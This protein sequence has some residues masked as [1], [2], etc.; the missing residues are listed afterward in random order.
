MRQ[1]ISD[2]W[3]CPTHDA[4]REF[5]TESYSALARKAVF[6]LQRIKASGV[7]GDDYHHKTLW[8]EYCHEVKEGPYDLLEDAWEKT[9]GPLLSAMID[10]IPRHEA[11]LLTIGAIWEL[12]EERQPSTGVDPQLIQQSLRQ[13]IARIADAR[14][15]SRFDPTK[16]R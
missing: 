8:D 10:T 9:L 1:F 11:I 16:C 13:A 12:N 7:F 14:D 5:A 2:C 15:L 6:Q 4:V 3:S